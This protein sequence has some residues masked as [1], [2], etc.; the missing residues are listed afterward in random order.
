VG[1]PVHIA[2]DGHAWLVCVR[3]AWGTREFA[4]REEAAGIIAA[5]FRYASENLG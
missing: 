2:F 4:S 5:G 1:Y 3:G